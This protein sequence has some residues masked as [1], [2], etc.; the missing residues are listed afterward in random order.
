MR[1]GLGDVLASSFGGIEI[2]R[3]PGIPPWGM[4]EHIP[5]DYDLVLCVIGEK[6]ETQKILSDPIKINDIALIGRY[7]TK[8]LLERPSLEHLF[9]L[10]QEFTRKI[11]IADDTVLQAI[12]AANHFGMASMCMLGNAVFAIGNTPL[13]SQTL[14]VFGK[15]YCCKVDNIGARIIR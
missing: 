5:G 1:T 6:I 13:L 2:R 10:A 11:N 3:E 7:C 15:I 4:I 8:K 14:S 12:E 9:F